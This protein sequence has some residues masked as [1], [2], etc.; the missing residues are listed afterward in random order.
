MSRN[1]LRPY[2]AHGQIP[3][4]PRCARPPRRYSRAR[5][6]VSDHVRRDVLLGEATALMGR[7][8]DR[9]IETLFHV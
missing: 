3:E 2:A 1:Q 5:D 6:I 4:E 8:S 7:A 9:E